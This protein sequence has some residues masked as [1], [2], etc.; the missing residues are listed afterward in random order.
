MVVFAW[1]N[2]HGDLAA[3]NGTAALERG[4]LEIRHIFLHQARYHLTRARIL[5]LKPIRMTLGAPWL[6]KEGFAIRSLALTLLELIGVDDVETVIPT[7][8]R[9]LNGGILVIAIWG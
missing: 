7:V 3:A 8:V 5:I 4:P 2:H 6:V 1:M 9:V